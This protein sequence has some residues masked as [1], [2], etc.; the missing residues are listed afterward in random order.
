LSLL[1]ERVS[2]NTFPHGFHGLPECKA[3]YELERIYL[4]NVDASLVSLVSTTSFVKAFW[5]S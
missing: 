4:K 2:F 5:T 3:D 1:G